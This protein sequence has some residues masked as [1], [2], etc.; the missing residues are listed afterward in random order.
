[1]DNLKILIWNLQDFFVFLDKWNGQDLNELSEAKWQILSSSFKENKSLTHVKE[2]ANL[3]NKLDVD[4][5]LLTEVG[6]KESLENFN[7]HFLKTHY[8]TI[9]FPTNSDRGIDIGAFISP[10]IEDQIIQTKFHDHK[11]FA[12]G[13]LEIS[14]KVN[15]YNL[16]ILHTHLKSKLNLKGSDFEGRSQR[17]KEVNSIKNIVRKVRAKA[18]S[19]VMITGD[20]NGV[21]YKDNT[22]EELRPFAKNL[23][24][25]DALDHL[26]RQLFERASYIY[27][28]K[29]GEEVLMQLDYCLLEDNLAGFLS[30]ETRILDFS[31]DSRTSFP[32]NR[33]EKMSLPSDHYPLFIE[34]KN[35]LKETK[36]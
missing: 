17:Q 19:T 12:R 11:N 13:L 26:D 23:G 34:L 8:R 28:N 15:K 6:G 18:H 31:G 20:L 5:I 24:L 16:H 10:K 3:I 32:K 30:Q 29:H 1:M 25:R 21:I 36:K 22:E 35:L 4:I 7:Q 33:S 27:Y 9:H 2:I 14:L